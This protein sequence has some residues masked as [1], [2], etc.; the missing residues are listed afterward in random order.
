MHI[1]SL[2]Y[3]G[4]G[5]KDPLEWLN[6]GTEILGMMPA[7]AIPG[8]SWGFPQDPDFKIASG[9]KGIADDGS[10]YL[11]LDEY[12][13]RLGIHPD[14]DNNGILYIGFEVDNV[15]ELEKAKE[16]LISNK[17]DVLDGT[18]DE[19]KSR[20][21]GGLIKFSDPSGNPI[22]IYYE[23]TLDYK[24]SSPI[25]DHSFVASS[26]GLGHV[27]ILAANREQTFDFYT[28]IM[29]FKLS[30]YISFTNGDGAWFM[31]CNPRH[32]TMALSKFGEAN[33]MHHIMFEVDSIDTVGRALDRVNKAGV[34]ISSTLGKHINDLTTSFYMK[35]PNGW[36]VE[37]GANQLY[38]HNDN[39]WI[40]KQFVEGDIWGHQ[41]I[42]DSVAEVSGE[43]EE[44][45]KSDG[46]N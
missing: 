29:G 41:G 32:H 45:A 36:D 10:V 31:R 44:E 5:A 30:D 8:E 33:G 15:T 12:Q 17:V 42:M 21:V 3:I 37:I 28:K 19:A 46:K 1:K 43:L 40:P 11:K 25:P 16:H 35:G 27:M 24:F 34:P 38:I 4:F 2:G 23:P 18:D 20:S 26:F 14:N 9:G 39:E 6:F 22:E 7:R 13:W